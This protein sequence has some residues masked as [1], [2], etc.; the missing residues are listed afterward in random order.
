MSWMESLILFSGE[1]RGRYKNIPDHPQTHVKGSFKTGEALNE[2]EWKEIDNTIV[3]K[4]GD[5]NI[6]SITKN[7]P[8]LSI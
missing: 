4:F 3:A 5:A 1:W 2:A 7:A 6:I 8:R